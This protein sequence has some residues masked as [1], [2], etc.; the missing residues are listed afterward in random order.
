M[1]RAMRGRD[2]VRAWRA[3][4]PGR[5]PLK[6]AVRCRRMFSRL[7]ALL[8]APVP[9][10]L[11]FVTTTP[12]YALSRPIL[13]W[14]LYYLIA[15]LA[16]WP[17]FLLTK[18]MTRRLV[19]SSRTQVAFLLAACSLVLTAILVILP[20]S[21]FN[22]NYNWRDGLRDATVVAIGSVACLYVYW[23]VVGLGRRTPVGTAPNQRLERP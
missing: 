13:D 8:A 16:F 12:P 18:Y 15:H 22:A 21:I 10:T 9:L 14:L 20:S 7:A 5:W 11:T 3:I 19:L 1:K 17:S 23:A 4:Q 6:L 2:I